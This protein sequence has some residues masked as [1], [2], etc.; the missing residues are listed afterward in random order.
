[1]LI[2]SKA[3]C[4]PLACFFVNLSDEK[5]AKYMFNAQNIFKIIKALL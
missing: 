2:G 4:I 3:I 5:A 1:M